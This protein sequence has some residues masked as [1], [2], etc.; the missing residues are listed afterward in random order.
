M[1]KATATVDISSFTTDAKWR[2]LGSA[3]NTALAAAGFV[4]TSDTGQ[5]NW[6]TV[7]KPTAVNTIAGY[8]IW[9][10]NDSL[11]A[12]KPIYFKIEY[13][14]NGNTASGNSMYIKFTLATGSNGSGSLTGTSTGA[15][16]SGSNYSGFAMTNTAM[17]CQFTHSTANG[18]GLLN[19]GIAPTAASG[20]IPAYT[21]CGFI[22]IERTKDS[23]GNP[24]GNGVSVIY[25]QTTSAA[26]G[27]TTISE[28]SISFDTP[29][30]FTTAVRPR[31]G[32]LSTAETFTTG[33]IAVLYRHHTWIGALYYLTGRLSHFNTDQANSTTYTATPVGSTSHT[34]Y[35]WTG[36]VGGDASGSSNIVMAYLWE[37]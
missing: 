32:A 33:S 25:H 31:C 5:I 24:T 17:L 15:L 14:S 18:Y 27:S 10:F 3:Y 23:S 4:Q 29:A 8:E 37:D 35:V 19:F 16:F 26:A 22:I 9:R 36:M 28:A 30:A 21:S 12:T 6:T 11:Q 13:Q 34:Y 7:N 2:T 1:T 20:T